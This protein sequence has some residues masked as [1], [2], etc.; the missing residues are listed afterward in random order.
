MK[1]SWIGRIEYLMP[2]NLCILSNAPD[3]RPFPRL[4]YRPFPPSK[5]LLI[6]YS[7]ISALYVLYPLD[8]RINLSSGVSTIPLWI[9]FYLNFVISASLSFI[10]SSLES[11]I[12]PL[13]L[14]SI[15]KLL[16]C[17]PA[18][19]IYLSLHRYLSVVIQTVVAKHYQFCYMYLHVYHPRR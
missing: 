12:I 19:C 4:S 8:Q 14:R 11:C 1:R 9:H 16:F 7:L 3:H 10:A 5:V 2:N 17:P 18:V 13:V 15:F 6:N